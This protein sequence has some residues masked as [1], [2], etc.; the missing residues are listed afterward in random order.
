MKFQK[1]SKWLGILLIALLVAGC[2]VDQQQITTAGELCKEHEG[3]KLIWGSVLNISVDTV[4]ND[5]AEIE[6]EFVVRN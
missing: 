1:T 2:G 5:G 3:V 4:C 6:M